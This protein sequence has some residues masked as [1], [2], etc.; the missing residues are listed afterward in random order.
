MSAS[1]NLPGTVN[2]KKRDPKHQVVN[3]RMTAGQK[4]LLA[5]AAAREGLGLSTWLLHRGLLYAD[6]EA[7]E[8]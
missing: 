7:Q 3:V 1:C 2:V 6:R 5:A 4:K 8:R